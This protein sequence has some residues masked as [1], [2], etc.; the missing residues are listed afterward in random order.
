MRK[1]VC[2]LF[3]VFAAAAVF[4]AGTVSA[5]RT[6]A[7]RYLNLAI[8][9]VSY[10]DYDSADAL[11]VT[12][13]S[14]D[15]TIADFWF[16]RAKAAAET[17]LP[18]KD[19]IAYLETAVSLTDWLNY[20]NTN[21][22]IML[23]ELYYKTGSYNKCISVLQSA[24]K[25]TLPQAYYLQAASLYA[26]NREKEARTIISFSSSLF[27]DNAEFLTLFFK[28][29]F[30]IIENN[31]GT[32]H[33]QP[34]RE[35]PSGEVS[36][37]LLKRVYSVYE[38]DPTLLLYAAFFAEPEESYNLIKLYTAGTDLYGYDIF[39]P[40]AALRCGFISETEAFSK[41]VEIADGVFNYDMLLS[42]ASV[43]KSDEGKSKLLG[44]LSGF[45]GVINFSA[46]KNTVYDLSCKYNY[47][48]PDKI[49]YDRNNDGVIEWTVD[50]DYGTPVLFNDNEHNIV[51]KYH[52]FPSVKSA[53][54]ANTGI[55]YSFVPFSMNWTPL[56][57]E[58]APFG[59]VSNPFFIP[60]VK[61][62]LSEE[63]CINEDDAFSNAN[64]TSFPLERGTTAVFSLYKGEPVRAVYYLNGTEYADAVFKNGVLTARNVDMDKDGIKE[65]SEV[66]TVPE[67]EHSE[68][69]LKAIAEPVFGNMPYKHDVWLSELRIDTDGDSILDYK[70]VYSEDGWTHTF[71][72]MDGLGGYESS[73]SEN[74]DKSLR[75]SQF[76]HPLDKVLITAMLRGDKLITVS[77]G[78]VVYS[79]F[80]DETNDFYWVFEKPENDSF[81]PEIKQKLDEK[82][83]G[84]NVTIIYNIDSEKYVVAEK[85]CGVYFGVLLY[86]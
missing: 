73:Y 17:G 61:D 65:I 3:L 70:T 82:G 34:Y 22:I 43:I 62:G 31:G 51:L 44:F 33:S 67:L 25:Y 35:T 14:Y 8:N 80:Y 24:S 18:A 45:S 37:E 38:A 81:V 58:K 39:Y 48:R 36:T 59:D 5:G 55:S 23:A 40:Y 15:E 54:F 27:P 4:C 29:E 84:L 86:E 49:A 85:T 28:S 69:E 16:I 11:A 10:G 53:D 66:Y 2:S 56:L 6:I 52:S 41:Y 20:N 63:P 71:W 78:K 1:K 76:Y 21:A 64:Q 7:I 26:I 75:E 47:G 13:L 77:I 79:V 42:M 50:C 83:S 32:V 46:N 72:G 9:A 57:M 60:V 30:N 68:E 74:A 19:S 12:G